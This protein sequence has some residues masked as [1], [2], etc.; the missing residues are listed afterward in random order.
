MA[1]EEITL[2]VSPDAARAF[3]EASRQEQ[4]KLEVLV[5]LQ[6]LGKLQPARSL[7]EVIEDMSRQAQERGLT[8]EIL[9]ALL[10][11]GE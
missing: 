4:L 6:L 8:P 11:D 7:D 9:E 2:R 10:R 5:S 1:T 3:R